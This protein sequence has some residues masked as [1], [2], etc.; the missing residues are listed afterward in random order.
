MEKRSYNS[1]AIAIA[2]I[3]ITFVMP[4]FPRPS[5]VQFEKTQTTAN[6]SP[7]HFAFFY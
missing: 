1:I 2:Q 4:C 3:K 7:N 5:D 6:S